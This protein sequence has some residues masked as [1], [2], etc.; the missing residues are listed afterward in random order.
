M[1]LAVDSAVLAGLDRKATFLIAVPFQ[2]F[3][4]IRAWA[5]WTTEVSR[6]WI[7]PRHTNAVDGSICAF[8][9]SEGTWKIG[10]DLVAL[11][12]QYTMWAFCQLHLE[13]I[14]WWPGRQTA[15]FVY[16][17][18]T[19]LKDNEWCGCRPDA[20]RYAE[21]CKQSDLAAD[22]FQ[23]AIQF[24]GGFLK[25][26]PRQPPVNVSRLIWR[27]GEPPAFEQARTNLTLF[28]GSCLCPGK[29]GAKLSD[30]ARWAMLRL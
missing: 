3:Q 19:E 4:P 6:T 16:E 2:H 11:I 22:R 9:P 7:G 30:A 12:D 28:V 26:K 20:G 5:F 10:G 23:A 25:F 18:L 8:N 29:A 15:E 13:I 17:R 1:W 27:G 14:G 21:C 24:V